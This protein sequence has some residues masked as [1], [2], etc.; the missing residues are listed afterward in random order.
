MIKNNFWYDYVSTSIT[1]SKL[2]KV[3]QMQNCERVKE[4]EC[5]GGVFFGSNQKIIFATELFCFY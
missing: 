2:N 5:L 4:E 3:F 1:K